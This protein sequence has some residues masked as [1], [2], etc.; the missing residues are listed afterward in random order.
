MAVSPRVNFLIIGVQ[1]GGTT[2]LFDYLGDHADLALSREKELHFFDDDT[3]DW[4]A[5][6]GNTGSPSR[7]RD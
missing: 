3:Q 7:R 4:A 1:K 5:P 6:Y 2:A